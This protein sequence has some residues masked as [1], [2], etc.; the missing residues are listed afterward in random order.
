MGKLF[1]KFIKAYEEEGIPIWGMTIQNE[2][3]AVQRWKMRIY[4]AEEERDFE[5]SSWAYFRAWLT[6][7]E[8]HSS[9]HNRDLLFDRA[10][11]IL[12]DPVASKYVWG[13][14]FHWYEDW[15][16]GKPMSIMLARLQQHSQTRN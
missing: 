12:N 3:M 2:P 9:N 8:N 5:I 10:S 15:K 13:T 14:G 7:Q 4:T 16:D 1:T 6:G 11:V